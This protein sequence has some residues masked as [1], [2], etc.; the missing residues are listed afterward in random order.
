MHSQACVRCARVRAVLGSIDGVAVVALEL[1]TFAEGNA[2]APHTYMHGWIVGCP[3]LWVWCDAGDGG[4][5]AGAREW[6]VGGAACEAGLA[7]G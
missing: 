1:F 2:T 6:C 3:L 5:V 7:W 4:G